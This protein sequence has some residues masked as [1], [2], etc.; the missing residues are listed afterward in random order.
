MT[1]PPDLLIKTLP[2]ARFPAPLY[3]ELMQQSAHALLILNHHTIVDANPRAASLFGVSCAHLLNTS[4]LTHFPLRQASGH[5]SLVD[6]DEFLQ[7]ADADAKVCFAWL[8]QRADGALISTQVMLWHSIVADEDWILV[9]IRDIAN[10]A[11]TESALREKQF[12]LQT[13]LDNFPGGI[14]ILDK[15]LR[16][17]AW[18]QQMLLLM[19]YTEAVFSTQA[20]PSL[21]DIFRLDM[22]RGEYRQLQANISKELHVERWMARARCFEPYMYELRRSNGRVLEVRGVPIAEGGFVS[23]YQDVTEQYRI[24]KS[25]QKQSLLLREVLEHMS[26]GIAV[27]DG[28]LSLEVWNSAVADMLD[29]PM[30]SFSTGVSYGDLV[31]ILLERGEFGEVDVEQELHKR[32]SIVRQFLGYRF[33]RTRLNGRTF[34]IHGKPLFDEGKV[35]KFITT[36]A[37]I[38]ERKQAEDTLRDAH[39]RLEK[40]VRELNL[41]RA[42]LVR[43]EKLVALG[44]LVAGVAHELNTPLGNCLMM[45]SAMQ[46]LTEHLS[47]KLYAQGMSK[48]GLIE[49]FNQVEDAVDFLNRN[50]NSVGDLI[51]RFKQVTMTETSSQRSTFSVEAL[52]IE[53]ESL[54]H[55]KVQAGGHYLRLD[56]E[57][58]LE[59]LSY[60]TPLEQVLVSFINNSLLHAF[61]GSTGGSMYFSARRGAG[62]RVLIEFRDDGCGIEKKNLGRIFDPFFT[63]RMGQ[64]CS[65]LGLQ[66]SHNIVT[67][68]LGGELRV[69]SEL[70]LGTTFT[71][72]LPL[73]APD[74]H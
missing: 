30:E 15:S 19:D 8:F 6:W 34:L 53:V 45:A 43:S 59:M 51:Q 41:A 7:S 55:S 38:T 31:R 5:L 72:S 18:N 57:V 46:E 50:L 22:E 39:A 63:T 66:I 47:A 58:G 40:L 14:S 23:I 68:L 17:V 2:D 65:G 29:L 25:L 20:P 54:T 48:S 26:A 4:V 36:W 16:F 10:H 61:N 1:L 70:G 69:Q 62:E 52:A 21:I 3:R 56:I 24:S 9:E 73:H 32:L 71:L 49:Y 42:E 64:G 13:L 67:A 44:S 28:N 33:E 74:N 37:E 27:F 35:V 11:L 12:Q 60:F